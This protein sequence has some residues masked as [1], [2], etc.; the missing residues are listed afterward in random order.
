MAIILK[1]G[2]ES[3][4]QMLITGCYITQRKR[5]LKSKIKIRLKP[6]YKYNKKTGQTKL[7]EEARQMTIIL[8]QKHTFML[9]NY[10]LDIVYQCGLLNKLDLYTKKGKY[11]LHDK[12]WNSDYLKEKSAREYKNPF[13]KRV[14]NDEL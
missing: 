5:E 12:S 6:V 9:A 8:N 13:K 14:M 7:V 11:S 1:T 3:G 4:R 10:F 2:G